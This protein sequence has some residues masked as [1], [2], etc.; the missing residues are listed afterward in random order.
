MCVICNNII[1][2]R[3]VCYHGY[4]FCILWRTNVSLII[5][6]KLQNLIIIDI[7]FSTFKQKQ[8]DFVLLKTAFS[9][10]IHNTNTQLTNR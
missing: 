1:R 6:W 8:L 4:V 7:Y 2:V 10:K 9:E 3:V 5:K